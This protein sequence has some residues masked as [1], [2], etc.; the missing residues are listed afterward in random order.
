MIVVLL[1]L[2]AVLS[3][4][5]KYDN[6]SVCKFEYEGEKL[7]AYEFMEIYRDKCFDISEPNIN[8]LNVSGYNISS[9]NRG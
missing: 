2:I 6:C 8:D 5:Y 1:I 3:V 9:G 7:R 4:Y